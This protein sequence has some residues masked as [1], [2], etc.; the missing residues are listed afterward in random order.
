VIT[1]FSLLQFVSVLSAALFTGAAFTMALA[2][3]VAVKGDERECQRWRRRTMRIQNFLAAAGALA[4][5]LA[6]LVGGGLLWIVG[7][8]FAF[9]VIP[10]SLPAMRKDGRPLSG[11]PPAV[12]TGSAHALQIRWTGLH[13]LRSVFGFV[14]SCIYVTLAVNL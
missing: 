14:A 12:G 11:P 10:C 6:W 2:E 5:A 4:G 3:P 13:A 7:A 9:A 1:V 8:V